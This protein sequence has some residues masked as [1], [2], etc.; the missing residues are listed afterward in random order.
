MHHPTDRITHTTAFVTPVVEHWQE[1]EIAQWVHPHEGS[2]R[3]PTAPWANALPLSYILLPLITWRRGGRSSS[4]VFVFSSFSDTSFT[5]VIS[6]VFARAR[7]GLQ[8]VLLSVLKQHACTCN[9]HSW[10][11]E[12]MLN[13]TLARNFPSAIGCQTMVIFLKKIHLKN[14]IK[15]YEVIKHSVKRWAK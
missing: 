5:Q 7:L 13:G 4:T 6:D 8:V 10:M 1:R 15:N 14:C 12:S 11:K 3:R 2:I 9:W